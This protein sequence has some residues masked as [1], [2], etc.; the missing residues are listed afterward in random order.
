MRIL[1]TGLAGFTGGF[2]QSE[3]ESQ[4]HVV[5]GLQSDLL[6]VSTLTAEVQQ[7][8]PD[9]VIHLAGI[10]FVG[11]GE[12]NDFYQANLLGSRNLLAALA[13]AA[14]PPQVVLLASSA[15]VY[16]NATVAVI[17]ENTVAQYIEN[18]SMDPMDR[19][20][21]GRTMLPA[22]CRDRTG[23]HKGQPKPP[24]QPGRLI[25]SLRPI[26]RAR[27]GRVSSPRA[28]LQAPL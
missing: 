5:Y 18:Y 20:P 9:A 27:E 17:T 23:K 11:H 12:A 13:S 19:S 1:V 6:D 7:Q 15:N 24:P 28:A 8:A 14:T 21:A 26:P 4:G 2:L 22:T 10:A 16:G 3:L 25:S